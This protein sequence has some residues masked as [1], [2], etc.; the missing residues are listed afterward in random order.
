M[1]VKRVNRKKKKQKNSQYVSI[2]TKALKVLYSNEWIT[3]QQNRNSRVQIKLMYLHIYANINYQGNFRLSLNE[4]PNEFKIII[5]V[6]AKKK[7]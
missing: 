4:I 5:L 6:Y 3:R 2:R 1:T 7:H